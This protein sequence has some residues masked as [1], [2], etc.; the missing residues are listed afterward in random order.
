MQISSPLP[1]E[2]LGPRSHAPLGNPGAS[3]TCENPHLMSLR[4]FSK[5]ARLPPAMAALVSSQSALR[6]Q[7]W[8]KMF[9]LALTSC[10]LPRK[11]GG[12][13][14]TSTSWARRLRPRD[15]LTHPQSHSKT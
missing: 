8:D 3:W 1:P 13:T 5:P 15:A 6:G 2:F 14:I 4:T 11:L 7:W 10:L 9:G 12:E